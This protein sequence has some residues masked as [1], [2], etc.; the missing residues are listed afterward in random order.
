MLDL[1][2][3]TG[4]A[5]KDEGRRRVKKKREEEREKEQSAKRNSM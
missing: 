1:I 2:R 4:C 5:W 3:N